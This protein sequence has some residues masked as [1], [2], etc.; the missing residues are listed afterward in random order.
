MYENVAF[1]GNRYSDL[2]TAN[3]LAYAILGES[4]LDELKG[5]IEPVVK[6]HIPIL[7]FDITAVSES[8]HDELPEFFRYLRMVLPST[9]IIV[10]APD[11]P[12]DALCG[13]LVR[14]GIYDFVVNIPYDIKARRDKRLQD[15]IYWA[16]NNPHEFYEVSKYLDL[17]PN[18]KPQS[19][20]EGGKKTS[21]FS[22]F[23][24][25][26]PASAQPQS[27]AV[28][29]AS[30]LDQPLR[31]EIVNISAFDGAD[32]ISAAKRLA[33]SVTGRRVLV[34][35]LTDYLT[36]ADIEKLPADTTL[37]W[38]E[39]A[40]KSTP[41]ESADLTSHWRELPQLCAKV[42]GYEYYGLAPAYGHPL[43]SVCG[44]YDPEKLKPHVRAFLQG[45]RENFDV[46]FAITEMGSWLYTLCSTDAAETFVVVYPSELTNSWLGSRDSYRT[47]YLIDGGSKKDVKNLAIRFAED[48]Y[49]G[50]VEALPSVVR[51]GKGSTELAAMLNL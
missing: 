7:V 36:P 4:S 12:E 44:E 29:F 34:V 21:G 10:L 19:G 20:K 23:R 24:R 45:C 40:A 43:E 9:R 5:R 33:S 16:V 15:E 39:Y 13:D 11:L 48:K 3:A 38:A 2:L 28:D 1:I 47:S 31:G 51:P 27:Q 49:S 6:S 30:V 46:T 8:Q 14:L 35:L 25:K 17:E 50:R 32:A 26:E 18:K 22:L 37:G 42:S 41:N